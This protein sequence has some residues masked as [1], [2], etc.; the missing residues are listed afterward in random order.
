MCDLLCVCYLEEEEFDLDKT[1]V[2]LMSNI[3]RIW[4]FKVM[5]IEEVKVEESKEDRLYKLKVIH[6]I[7]EEKRVSE[8]YER[9]LEISFEEMVNKLSKDFKDLKDYEAKDLFLQV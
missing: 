1:F 8:L 3:P 4:S 6:T 5:A 2:R 7:S 9:D